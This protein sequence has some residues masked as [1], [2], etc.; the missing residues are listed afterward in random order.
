MAEFQ[1]KK[2]TEDLLSALRNLGLEVDAEL[3]PARD[4]RMPMG[5]GETAPA[6]LAEIPS[7][8]PSYLPPAPAEAVPTEPLDREPG[9][10]HRRK[11]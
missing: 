1:K 3:K 2:A 9:E 4:R 8:A 5:P 7:L 10:R 11:T 6:D